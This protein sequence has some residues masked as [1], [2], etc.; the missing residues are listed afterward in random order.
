MQADFKTNIPEQEI[1][2]GYFHLESSIE[3]SSSLVTLSVSPSAVHASVFAYHSHAQISLFQEEPQ[4]WAF[5]FME[6]RS[7]NFDSPSSLLEALA[8][9]YDDPY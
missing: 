5:C 2:K 4:A 3:P 1:E 8:K 9:L 6:Q 7:K